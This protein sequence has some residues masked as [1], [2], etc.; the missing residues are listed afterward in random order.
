M[1]FVNGP[2]LSR[3][4]RDETR[5]ARVTFEDIIRWF[6][7]VAEALA[8]LH[9]HRIVHGDLK[10]DNLLLDEQSGRLKITEFGTSRRF[11]NNLMRT[12]R[13]AVAWAYQAPEIQQAN[14]RGAVSDLFSLGAVM[15]HTLTGRL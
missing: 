6:A 7:G 10:P 8:F 12:T 14:Q 1:E 9:Q 4:M 5:W 2:S 13:H 15:Y 3:L 11:T